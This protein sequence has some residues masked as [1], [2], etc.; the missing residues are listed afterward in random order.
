VS[1][2][3]IIAAIKECSEKFGHAPSFAEL[4]EIT[5]LTKRTL[6]R[7]FLRYTDALRECGLT[8]RGAGYEV[9]REELLK[10]WARMVR[11]LGKLPSIQEYE[12]ES[13]YSIRPM[14]RWFRRWRNIPD[15]M[16][17]YLKK[18]GLDVEYGDVLDIIARHIDGRRRGRKTFDP[19]AG[20]TSGS[21]LLDGQPIYGTP[22]L[23]DVMSYAPT[24]EQ[25]VVCLFG[26]MARE[27]KFKLLRFQAECPDCEA[28]R[29]VAPGR[30]QRVR[31]E[32]EFE[33]RNFLAHGHRPGDCDLIVCWEHNWQNCPVEVIEL[34][35]A[36]SIQQSALSQNQNL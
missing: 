15:G 31:I 33:S 32:F 22:L 10:E 21:R 11:K 27:L 17:E 12:L 36:I 28:M 7:H 14:L 6:R 20:M 34:R 2:E 29:E 24:N 9:S 26:A 25:G 23:H 4:Q 1:K 35:K 5:M 13:E 16:A 19:P 3:E 8:R 30:W 18:E